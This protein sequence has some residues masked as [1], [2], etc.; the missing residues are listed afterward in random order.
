MTQPGEIRAAQTEKT[1]QQGYPILPE[2]TQP[3]EIRAAQT[4]KTWQQGSF[5]IPQV[6]G[7]G[8]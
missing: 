4:E 8:V 7:L 3:G 1:W 5:S 6:F 2:M